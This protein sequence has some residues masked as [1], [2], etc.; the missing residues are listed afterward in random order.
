[1]LP[2]PT[3]AG[4]G[5]LAPYNASDYVYS[6]IQH[7]DDGHP[8]SDSS[9]ARDTLT[10]N[11][12]LSCDNLAKAEKYY[13]LQRDATSGEYLRDV[14]NNYWVKLI[15]VFNYVLGIFFL[16][17]AN[18]RLASSMSAPG[19][20]SSSSSPFSAAARSSTLARPV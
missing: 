7:L 19:S 1:M 18:F 3:H 15:V 4:P 16:V 8:I 6:S 17:F 13:A 10:A 20:S 14:E 11:D 2:T 9:C 5:Y 12:K